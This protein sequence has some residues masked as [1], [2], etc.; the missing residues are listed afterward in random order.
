QMGLVDGDGEQRAVLIFDGDFLA[1]FAFLDTAEAAD[2]VFGMNDQIPFAD[3]VE[4]GPDAHRALAFEAA[5]A[6][7]TGAAVAAEEFAGGEDGEF[8]GGDGEA[9]HELAAE[10]DEVGDAFAGAE[11]GEAFLLALVGE[12]DAG[13]PAVRLPFVEL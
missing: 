1:V 7:R 5:F 2:A 11:F 13:L 12:N 10:G 4:G 8:R 9:L 3:V 6:E